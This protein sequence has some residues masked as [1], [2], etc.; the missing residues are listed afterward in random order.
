MIVMLP[1]AVPALTRSNATTAAH[2]STRLNQLAVSITRPLAL[3]IIAR[4]YSGRKL[5][6]SV[7][8]S[9]RRDNESV[10]H[11]C[12]HEFLFSYDVPNLGIVH[13]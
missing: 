2:H 1:R 11:C 5:L 6:S 3:G 12:L 7:S 10:F 8:A 9:V 13:V 4:S